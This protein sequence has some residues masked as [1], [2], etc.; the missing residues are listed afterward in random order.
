[1]HP[2]QSSQWCFQTGLPSTISILSAGQIAAH[3]PQDV[4]LSVAVNF[5][6]LEWTWD[7]NHG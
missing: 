7:V 3:V 1:M 6:S 5:L 2:Q 4:H